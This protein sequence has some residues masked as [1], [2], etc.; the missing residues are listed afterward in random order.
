MFNTNNLNISIRDWFQC[1]KSCYKQIILL[2]ALASV[3]GFFFF[4]KNHIYFSAQTTF[5]AATSPLEAKKM[6]FISSTLSFLSGQ[7]HNSIENPF[8]ITKYNKILEDIVL[9][10]NL[11]AEILDDKPNIIKR[12][13]NNIHLETAFYTWHRPKELAH[14]V[15]KNIYIPKTIFTSSPNFFSQCL[16]AEYRGETLKKLQITVLSTGDFIVFDTS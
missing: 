9:S 5:Q 1:I 13:L 15:S 6:D 14:L 2:C 3:V 11:Q 8:T 12:I 7:Q 4:T 16:C 10:A